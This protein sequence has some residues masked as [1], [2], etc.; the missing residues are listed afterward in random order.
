[1]SF[2]HVTPLKAKK[3]VKPAPKKVAKPAKK[4]VVRHRPIGG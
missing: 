1:M 4:K 2:R 3:T